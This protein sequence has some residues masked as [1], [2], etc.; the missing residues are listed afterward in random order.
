MCGIRTG[1]QSFEKNKFFEIKKTR[2]ETN[3]RLIW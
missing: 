3:Q 1:T 2:I